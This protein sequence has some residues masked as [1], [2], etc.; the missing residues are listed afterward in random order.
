VKAAAL[1]L[2][3]AACAARPQED[4]NLPASREDVAAALHKQIELVLERR[5]SLAEKTD[6]ASRREREELLR[7]AGE[8]AVRIARVDP[9][10]DL[11]TLVEKLERAQ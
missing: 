5:E 8:I 10:A 11:K 2:L 1:A 6:A 7:R 4:S 9:H 3:L